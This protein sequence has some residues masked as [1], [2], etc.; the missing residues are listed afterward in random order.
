KTDEQVYRW[1]LFGTTSFFHLLLSGGPR[2]RVGLTA[3]LHHLSIALRKGYKR[4]RRQ[5]HRGRGRRLYRRFDFEEQLSHIVG[6]SLLILLVDKAKF[7]QLVYIAQRMVACRIR[8]VRSPMVM[9]RR[10]MELLKNARLLH[11]LLPGLGMHLI[12]RQLVGTR[13]MQPM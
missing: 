9:N 1:R 11:R 3:R 6:P 13:D 10:P 2:S 7:A 12:R 8:K 5:A 4:Q